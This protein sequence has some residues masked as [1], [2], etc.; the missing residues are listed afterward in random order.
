MTESVSANYL[1][2][3]AAAV[4]RASQGVT[5]PGIVLPHLNTCKEFLPA[6]LELR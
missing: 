2:C 5:T 4:T 1:L 3:E 6:Y